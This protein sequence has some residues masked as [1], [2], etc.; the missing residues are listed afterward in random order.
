MAPIALGPGP[1]PPIGARRDRF[2]I[3]QHEKNMN[4]TVDAGWWCEYS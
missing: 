2:T 4:L 3:W 1:M